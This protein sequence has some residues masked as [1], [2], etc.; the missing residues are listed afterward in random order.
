MHAKP[1]VVLL[2]EDDSDDALLIQRYL[3]S[4]MKIP[5]QVRHVDRLEKGLAFLNSGGADVV[6]LDL[7][8]PDGNGL[9]TLD[10]A[11][12]LSPHI[13]II[14]LTGHDD[15]DIAV[16][17]LHNGAQDYLVK[18]K[19]D[20]GLLQRA[21]RYAIERN[22]LL[23]ELKE[24][25]KALRD[26]EAERQQAAEELKRLNGLLERQATTD[27]LTGISNRLKFNNTLETELQRSM[28]YALPLSLIMFDIDHFKS[29]NDTYGHQTGD[30]VLCELA[31][32][33]LKNVRLYDLFAR[34][35]GEEFMILVT[36]TAPDNV[37]MFAEKLRL[38]IEDRPFAGAGRVTCSFGVAHFQGDE[39]AD[40]FVQRVDAALYRAKAR[41]RNRV[42]MA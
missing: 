13:P 23:T 17:A 27:P 25:E 12:A 10:K 7:G 31:A 19:V 39:T 28:R 29:I 14:V 34:W 35:G 36:N 2:I 5:Y 20:G 32:L 38:R 11:H 6:L 16:E 30:S 21:I 3:S 15:D 26:G 22:K 42:E 9:R 1:I 37:R 4:A 40:R 8:L 18:G 33:T 41:G 24:A